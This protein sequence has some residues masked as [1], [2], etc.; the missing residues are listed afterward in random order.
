MGTFGCVHPVAAR[1]DRGPVIAV[2]DLV[3][4]G[5]KSV[6]VEAVGVEEIGQLFG[7]VEIQRFG[8]PQF[9]TNLQQ[10]LDHFERC[11]TLCWI[12]K[13]RHLFFKLPDR[14]AGRLYDYA[15]AV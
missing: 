10:T 14:S 1:D 8:K 15:G 13:G 3:V 9:R 2:V 11:E 5:R 12:L 6:D 4:F 7:P